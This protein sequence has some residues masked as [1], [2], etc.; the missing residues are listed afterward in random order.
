MAKKYYILAGILREDN[1]A[2]V[3]FTDLE[4]S[5]VQSEY[6]EEVYRKAVDKKDSEYR[7]LKI[8]SID[9]QSASNDS[10]MEAVKNYG[11][12]FRNMLAMKQSNSNL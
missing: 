10:I 1:A 7:A 4:R 12:Q 2:V 8:L 6:D 5:V 9:A 3:I 11:I